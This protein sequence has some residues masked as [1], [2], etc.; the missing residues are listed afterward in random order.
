MFIL[1]LTYARVLNKIWGLNYW[2]MTINGWEE[3]APR[4]GITNTGYKLEWERFNR[5]AIAD[6]LTWQSEIVGEYK[7]EYY[8]KR[9]QE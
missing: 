8:V 9:V 2:G 4:D 6:F 1:K 5:K 3:L 7:I